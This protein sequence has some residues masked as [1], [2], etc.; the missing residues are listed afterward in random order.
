MSSPIASGQNTVVKRLLVDIHQKASHHTRLHILANK[1]STLLLQSQGNTNLKC[2]DVGCGDMVLA[3]LIQEALPKTSWKCIDIHPLPTS[4]D[5]DE[6]WKKYSQFDGHSIPFNDKEFDFVFFCDVL[7]HTEENL[8]ALL[9][10]AARVAHFVVVKDH[11][12]YGLFSRSILQLMDI[13]GN[14]GYGVSI[15]K[16]YFNLRSFEKFSQNADLR[17]KEM[18]IGLHLYGHLPVVRNILRPKWQFLALLESHSTSK[19]KE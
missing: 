4:L 11:F 16:A 19:Q 10:E 3:E 6:K 2:L 17:I 1:I 9:K 12:E 14:W 7:H 8:L 13:V 18:N 5:K 15:P